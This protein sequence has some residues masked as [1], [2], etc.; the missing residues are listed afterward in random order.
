MDTTGTAPSPAA[1]PA[2]PARTD[3]SYDIH[4]L[5]DDKRLFWKNPNRGVTITDA[6]RA[7]CLTWETDG[8]EMSRLWTDIAAVNMTLATD[9]R[10]NVNHCRIRFR[11]GRIITV[12]DTGPD[13]RLDESRTP[14]YRD[15]ARA[16]NAR[17]A[18]APEGVIE[19]R[20]GVTEGRYLGMKIALAIAALLFVGTP[21]VL[22]MLVRYDWRILG[23]LSVGMAF[24]WPFW[25]AV[26]HNKPRSYDPRRPPP[27]LME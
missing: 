8:H 13:G 11:D 7:S 12:M 23:A 15:F 26:Q 17:L 3:K 5:L 1:K 14:I 19:F 16:L 20:A 18:K 6:G 27:E 25:K 21:L 2:P 24:M 4:F 22:L 10:N 9:G